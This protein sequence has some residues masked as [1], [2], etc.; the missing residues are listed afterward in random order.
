MALHTELD[1]YKVGYQ[2]LGKVTILVKNMERDFK[3]LIGEEI[4]R[5]S[6]KVLILVYRA[7][8]ASNKVP[9]LTDLV[10]RVQMIEVLLRLSMD[11][12]KIS[13]GQYAGVVKLTTSIGKQANGWRKSANRPHHGGQGRHD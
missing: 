8:I 11:M 3:R 4:A 13:P 9:H 5:E 1:I 12:G 6:A 10:E 7:N 2:L